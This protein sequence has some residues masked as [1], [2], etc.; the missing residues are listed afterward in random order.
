MF[1]GNFLYLKWVFRRSLH[2]FFFGILTVY[3]PALCAIRC[4]RPE[5][6]PA[7]FDFKGK[8][9]LLIVI[10][11]AAMIR[12][13]DSELAKPLFQI[14]IM[15]LHLNQ[16]TIFIKIN[17]SCFLPFVKSC[18]YEIP[19]KMG[20]FFR[21]LML[22]LVVLSFGFLLRQSPIYNIKP[23]LTSDQYGLKC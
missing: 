20:K 12:V 11:L 1:S 9:S 16:I 7:F 22:S 14:C 2:A 4:G 21:L 17:C 6:Q 10:G 23:V 18:F 5:T 3:F 8:P 19:L 13:H 15:G